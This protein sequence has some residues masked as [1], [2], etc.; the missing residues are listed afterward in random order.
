MG[1]HHVDAD[2]PRP[3]AP[4]DRAA[5]H[6]AGGDAWGL[7]SARVSGVG[8]LAADARLARACPRVWATVQCTHGRVGRDVWQRPPPG[9][10]LWC[11]GVAGAHPRGAMQK[12]LD[13]G[14]Q[15]SEPPSSAIATQARHALGNDSDDTPGWLTPTRQWRWGRVRNHVAF[16]LLHP[17]RSPE[18]CAARIDVWAGLLVREG[19]GVA[20]A[21]DARLGKLS[22][23]SHDRPDAAGRFA[24]RLRRELDALWVCVVHGGVDTTTTR[25]EWA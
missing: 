19:D 2:A 24:C 5:P 21:W 7:A 16:S 9:A 23:Q 6:H 25:A 12:G 18:A 22:D 1:P 3:D 15:A 17:R 10:A 8:M 14:A 11:L 4:G 13:R 20:H